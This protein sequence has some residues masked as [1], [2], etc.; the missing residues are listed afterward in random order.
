MTPLPNTQPVTSPAEDLLA[1]FTAG[2]LSG[3]RRILVES[4][5]ELG[6]WQEEG[7]APFLEPG[8]RWLREQPVTPPP[9]ALWER[10]SDQLDT[11]PAPSADEQALPIALRSEL[12]RQS[13]ALPWR[14]F[15][16]SAARFTPLLPGARGGE[17]LY[18][19]K[20]EGGKHFPRHLHL[21]REEI[22]V[23]EGAMRDEWGLMERGAYRL[24]PVGSEHAPWMEPGGCQIVVRLEGN[25]RFR[26]WRGL[27]QQ[28]LTPLIARR[29]ASVGA[30]PAAAHDAST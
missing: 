13:T 4:Y 1:A 20:M 9:A 30:Q 24:F 6:G 29:R 21:G 10:L 16:T 22:V 12:P 8:A 25:L 14:R 11:L 3:A 18:W 5:L 2:Q 17:Q 23:L 28:L 15:P 19:M 27:V 7:M 26:G